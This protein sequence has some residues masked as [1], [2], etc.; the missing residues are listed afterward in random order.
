MS[1][2]AHVIA[3]GSAPRVN[4]MPRAETERRA[5]NAL[6]RRWSLALVGAMGVVAIAMGGAFFLQLTSEQ[7]AAAEDA[8]TSDLLTRIAALSDV[9]AAVALEGELT[10][11]RGTAMAAEL[12]WSKVIGALRDT[13]PP[14]VA[15]AGFDLAVGGATV[16]DDPSAE[17]GASGT[18][19]FTTAV[20]IEMVS[21]TR[22]VRS[23][24]SVLDADGW[25]LVVDDNDIHTYTLRVSV[26]QTFYTGTYVTEDTP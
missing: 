19:T 9:R 14:D 6:I 15:M 8:R 21:L 13:M 4:L 18:V 10:D 5:N 3:V 7:R 25:E 22:A 20:P 1:G 24:E 16:G 2:S 11:F 23:L 12:A 17:P 26:D